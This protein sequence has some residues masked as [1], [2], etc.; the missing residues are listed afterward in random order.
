M[1]GEREGRAMM[2]QHAPR[3]GLRPSGADEVPIGMIA[4]ARGGSVVGGG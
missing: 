3:K 4:G 1:V 2:A